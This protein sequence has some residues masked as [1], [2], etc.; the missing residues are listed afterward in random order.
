MAVSSIYLSA[1][2]KSSGKTTVT[3][4]LCAALR[5]RGLKVQPFKKGPD[6]ID[7]IWLGMAAGHDCHNLDF[8]TMNHTE[9]QDVFVHQ[10]ALGEIS[11]IEG[12]KGLYDGLDLK[13]SNSNAALARL[14]GTPVVLIIDTRGMTRGVVPLLLGY[15]GFEPKVEI[16]GVL[17]NHV[18]GVRHEGKL[19][20]AIE[21]YTDLPVLGAIPHDR[22][23]QVPE[24]HLGLVPGNEFADP[25][26]FIASAAKTIET[27]VD[28]A[29]L[30]TIADPAPSRSAKMPVGHQA[31]HTTNNWVVEKETDAANNDTPPPRIKIA[32]ARDS[33]FGFYYPGDFKALRRAGAELLFFNTLS[34]TALPAADALFI[35]GGFPEVHM[36]ALQANVDLRRSIRAALEGGMPAYAECGGLMYLTRGISWR[37]KR[38]EMVGVIPGET[39]MHERP[40]GK[41]YVLLQETGKL[42][43][44]L[45]DPDKQAGEQAA[46]VKAHE[47]HHAGISLSMQGKGVRYA[48]QVLRGHGLDGQHDGIIHG[49][50]LAGFSH[51]RDVEEN[52]WAARFVEYACAQQGR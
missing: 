33:A 49:N 50:L 20:A 36:D 2:H 48:Y 39:I 46:K 27:H 21:Y 9:I 41:G 18:G 1:A 30:L 8:H 10:S 5:A 35:G 43:W 29:R 22:T 4:G 31:T 23:I 47:F 32:I 44:G 25:H 14:L 15:L 37:G 16:A 28:L 51:L 7:P 45:S 34:D 40:Q 19:R 26:G 38:C 12:N 17:L 42:P 24:R 13:G 6:Y 11:L 3:V 52:H